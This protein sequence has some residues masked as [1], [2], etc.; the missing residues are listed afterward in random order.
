MKFIIHPTVISLRGFPFERKRCNIFQKKTEK[1]K[2][3]G[4]GRREGMSSFFIKIL[5]GGTEGG[6]FYK[7]PK[8][9]NFTAMYADLSLLCFFGFCRL[10]SCVFLFQLINCGTVQLWYWC[11]GGSRKKRLRLKGWTVAAN[12]GG[13]ERFAD[14]GQAF[15]SL[16]ASGARV[17][18]KEPE[19]RGRWT[20]HV[21]VEGW[22]VFLLFSAKTMTA[23][24]ALHEATALIARAERRQIKQSQPKPAATRRRAK[25]GSRWIFSFCRRN[26]GK[27]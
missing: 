13:T 19:E 17:A 6:D 7:N 11:G 9:L 3:I 22:R 14:T 4:Q 15:A 2:P 8:G 10:V 16:P 20:A 24:S 5:P 12:S 27:G 1:R 23:R 26:G 25:H 18:D 21:E